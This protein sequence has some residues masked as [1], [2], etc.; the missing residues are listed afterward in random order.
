MKVTGLRGNNKVKEDTYYQMVKVK[1][2]CGIMEKESN[3]Q[4]KQNN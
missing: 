4:I 1:L 2:E 3:G